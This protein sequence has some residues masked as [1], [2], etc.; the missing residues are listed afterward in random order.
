[1]TRNVSK[2]QVTKHKVGSDFAPDIYWAVANFNKMTEVEDFEYSGELAESIIAYRQE[3]SSSPV[4][5]EETGEKYGRKY[6]MTYTYEAPE[7]TKFKTEW[8]ARKYARQ[9]EKQYRN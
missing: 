2:I 5:I 7:I 8:E 9:L 6:K 1:M 4:K 3:R